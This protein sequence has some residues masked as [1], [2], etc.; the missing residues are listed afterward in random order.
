MRPRDIAN[1]MHVSRRT[2]YQWLSGTSAIPPLA[3]ALVAAYKAQRVR[4][5]APAIAHAMG[6]SVRTVH[7]W[8]S[9]KWKV[10]V[11]AIA[12]VAQNKG[13]RTQIP[14]NA[15]AP[16]PCVPPGRPKTRGEC[17][18]APRP[19][20]WES[21]RY[22]LGDGN[23]AAATCCLDVADRGGATLDE[24]GEILH[25]EGERVRQ[26]EA[27]ALSVISTLKTQF[28]NSSASDGFTLWVKC[29][30]LD[31]TGL[32]DIHSRPPNDLWEIVQTGD[33]KL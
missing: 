31:W 10:P 24:I 22:H 33:V 16:T 17:V 15:V 23:S 19:C 30:Q 18:D 1:E 26:I 9:G 32:E 27:H 11:A 14:R 21:C 25:I 4:M 12:M 2:V 6:V 29:P 7:G 8:L 28:V 3:A 13:S 20:T 5:T